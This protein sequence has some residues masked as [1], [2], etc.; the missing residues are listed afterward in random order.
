M[1]PARNAERVERVEVARESEGEWV[2]GEGEG[3]KF[4]K[5]GPGVRRAFLDLDDGPAPFSLALA[6]SSESSLTPRRP[7][8]LLPP[9]RRVARER[10]R[11]P[12]LGLAGELDL[13]VPLRFKRPCPPAAPSPSSALL[14][15]DEDSSLV[16]AVRR[17]RDDRPLFPL[18][19]V[20][21][22]ERDAAERA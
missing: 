13:L 17:E 8:P 19:L 2:E 15:S 21:F 12:Y 14:A 22:A 11:L 9:S 10:E 4:E 3:R 7:A 16:R 5:R 6:P 18:A 20:P 1:S